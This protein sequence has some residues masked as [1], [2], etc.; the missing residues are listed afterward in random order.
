VCWE[1]YAWVRECS[2]EKQVT[3]MWTVCTDLRYSS[4]RSGSKIK[5]NWCSDLTAYRNTT[6][7]WWEKLF[8][9]NFL[10]LKLITIYGTFFLNIELSDY[11][12]FL[13]TDY[14]NVLKCVLT[15]DF[16][17]KG[18]FVICLKYM[19][20]CKTSSRFGSESVRHLVVCEY[21][22]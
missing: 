21:N 9:K 4:V 12:V 17:W 13:C 19:K 2:L 3:E 14:E 20:E 10:I 6:I 22:A 15:H 11:I 8:Y 1:T 16:L 7:P 5:W 18:K